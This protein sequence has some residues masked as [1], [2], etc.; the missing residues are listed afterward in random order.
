MNRLC[1]WR[2]ARP[3]YQLNLKRDGLEVV[4]PA[5]KRRAR[6]LTLAAWSVV[7]SMA[8]ATLLQG[9]GSSGALI[10]I[11][12]QAIFF[13]PYTSY[14]DGQGAL[15]ANNVRAGSTFVEWVN[16][17]SYLKLGF[18]GKSLRLHIDTSAATQGLMPKVRWTLD[19]APLTTLYLKRGQKTIEIA[20]KL[21][22]GPHT[23]AFYLAATD[24][25]AD[26]WNRP[27]QSLK[28]TGIEMDAGASA[29][30]PSGPIA[31]E[32]KRALLFGD[33]ITEGMWVLGD[34]KVAAKAVEF[35][36]STQAWPAMLA[37]ALG[38]E[39]GT[40]GFGGQSWVRNMNE[41]PPFPAAWKDYSKGRSRLI[42]GK[43]S[44]VPDYVFVNMGTNDST[45]IS[46]AAE[47][48]LRAL[49]KAAGSGTQVFVIIPF[50]QQRAADLKR[51]IAEVGDSRVFKLDLGPKWAYGLHTYG[52]AARV[53]YDGLH[54]D[55]QAAGRYAAAVAHAMAA[56]APGGR[57]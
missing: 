3:I 24:A 57:R 31:I 50:G 55:A 47:G 33:S 29:S 11:T 48:W 30:A 5:R 1:G 49:L 43:L 52:V 38:T 8:F 22:A 20:D 53:S 27:A 45:D 26:R 34:S 9:A 39:Y 19:D 32:P 23:L 54:P 4:R 2:F 25:Y 18:T 21:K 16:P 40:C 15:Q 7:A 56:A 10:L 42:D 12:D 14:S 28:I 51:A 6:R 35:N 17:G 13:S 46:A 41:V 36:D 44:P 37:E